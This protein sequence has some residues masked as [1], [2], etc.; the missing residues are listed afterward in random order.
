VRLFIQEGTPMRKLLQQA[1]VRG[2]APAYAA[3]LLAALDDLEP[4][5]MAEKYTPPQSLTPTSQPLVEPLTERE[6][7]VLRM[8]NTTLSGPE[9]AEELVI[10][11]STY[12][13][14]TKSI[15]S[16]LGVHSRAEA[17]VRAQDLN[18]I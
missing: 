8:L 10:S 13:S 9:I 16:K 14:H 18:L 6:L 15:Y 5:A 3:E 7:Q 2:I 12:R 17:I 1:T 11:P 4:G